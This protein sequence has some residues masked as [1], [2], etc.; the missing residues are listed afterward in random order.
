VAQVGE[1]SMDISGRMEFPEQRV[2]TL[3]HLVVA[4]YLAIRGY[5][6]RSAYDILPDRGTN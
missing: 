6:R 4:K 3:Q 5:P 2:P 1:T